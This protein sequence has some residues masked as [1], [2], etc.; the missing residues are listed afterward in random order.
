VG[1]LAA[2]VSGVLPGA[3]PSPLDHIQEHWRWSHFDQATGLPSLRVQQILRAGDGTVWVSTSKGAAW[4][5]GYFWHQAAGLG[6][7]PG[8]RLSLGSG[9]TIFAFQ[10]N[11]LYEGDRSGFAP[12]AGCQPGDWTDALPL[13][14]GEILA[15]TPAH[16]P[17]LFRSGAGRPAGFTDRL[18]LVQTS[19]FRQTGSRAV[20]WADRRGLFR[21]QHDSTRLFFAAQPGESWLKLGF[22]LAGL[23][24]N[25]AGA[26]VAAVVHPP[27]LAG[28]WEW[29]PGEAPR[30]TAAVSGLEDGRAIGV[31]DAGEIVLVHRS[32]HVWIRRPGEDWSE[33]KPLPAGFEQ[34]NQALFGVDGDLWLAT[35]TG[36][37]LYRGSKQGWHVW[38]HPFPDNRNAVNG[39]LQARDGTVWIANGAGAER[40][41]LEP[42]RGVL[43][44][45]ASYPL[46]LS[47]GVAEDEEG[48]I[49]I[50]SGLAYGGAWRWDGKSWRRFGR[51]QG[52]TDNRIHRINRDRRGR[53]W[54]TA[55]DGRWG[56]RP[57]EA[58]VY[59]L[60]KA[61][62]ERWDR[63]K[64][65][66]SNQVYSVAGTADGTLYF[67]SNEG[68]SRFG[69]GRW[70]HWRRQKELRSGSLFSVVTDWAGN[71]YWADR[72][73]GIGTLDEKGRARYFT[74]SD[75]LA[76]NE[77]WELA[78]D[79]QDAV[80]AAGQ[81]G[82]SVRRGNQWIRL[83]MEA[84]LPV[85]SAWPILR[86]GGQV[87][88]GL[89]AAGLACASSEARPD[90]TRVRINV[91]EEKDGSVDLSWQAA[92]N[93][94]NLASAAIE[95]RFR[96][97][98]GTWS[99]WSHRSEIR[100]AGLRSG[101][102]LVEVE[103]RG[104]DPGWPPARREFKV[105]G[106]FHLRP[107]FYVPI[108]LLALTALVLLFTL[109][110]R[111]R[112]NRLAMQL[113][114]HH[115]RSLIE[116]GLGGITLLNGGL[117]RTYES[118][119]V[120][121][122]LGYDPAF[123]MN[124]PRY[125]SLVHPD[126]AGLLREMLAACV[127]RD[128]AV[129]SPRYRV[130]HL[131]G[132]WI[133]LEARARNLLEDP[134]VRSIVVNYADVTGQVE[135][136][137]E[138]ERAKEQAERASR[139][140]SEFL[141][142]MSHEIRT[143]MNGITGMISLLLD[144]G[145]NAEQRDYAESIRGSAQALL[146]LI[147]DVLDVSRI[148]SGQL[149]I[150]SKPF[151]LKR[152]IHEVAELLRGLA[153]GKQLELRESIPA[154]LPEGLLGDAGRVRQVLVNLIGNAIKFTSR[155]SVSVRALGKL[156]PAGHCLVT[157]EVEDTGIGIPE[158]KLE[159]IFEQFVQADASTT[160]IYGGTGL[161]LSISRSLVRMMGGDL[162]VESVAG[163]GST[164]RAT[165]PLALAEVVA[166]TVARSGRQQAPDCR[167][168]RIL[169]A[170]D[171]PVN[172]RVA[173][174]M[175]EKLGASV[176]I[177]RNGHEA[178]EW[179]LGADFDLILMDCQ[180]P[181]MDGFEATRLVRAGPSPRSGV[182]IAA[183]TANAMSG[184]R[185]R[186]LAA[187]MDDF[188]AKPI[189]S[190]KLAGLLGRAFGGRA[191]SNQRSAVSQGAAEARM[192][193]S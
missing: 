176:E 164:F 54:F 61:G 58:G 35:E 116:N 144:T 135:A 91:V 189:D 102:H 143:P 27:R 57:E 165:L 33:V 92:S 151:N 9:S 69:G 107:V 85:E 150:E 95:T 146:E 192:L 34:V 63:G 127:A 173:L 98:G 44:R 163:R 125:G 13:E 32:G 134:A 186:C 113:R 29:G 22:H 46:G 115:Y 80:W 15:S 149:M 162:T 8:I 132:R 158:D 139:V 18:E 119:A 182:T 84:G 112:Q 157:I 78:V 147:N 94:G 74:E 81:G 12:V 155:G 86:V 121:R 7:H 67:A 105:E 50:S 23:A 156:G 31:S 128:G 131:D 66:L 133:W 124:T 183:L 42:G 93:L 148:E 39:L 96:L 70:T 193:K 130:R 40:V 14:S 21:M 152:T 166:E 140:K 108:C 99:V 36:V 52:L 73:N 90:L 25:A 160:R 110:R 82:V 177:A 188:L 56:D 10:S 179:A 190:E 30:R 154:E 26:G 28:V 138:L 169:L 172:Q 167:G 55:M 2:L 1:L 83:G 101:R 38:A 114:E 137:Q 16:R 45:L 187:G 103:S 141:A 100:L 104:M 88:T 123:L 118:P 75:G 19:E 77:V 111:T 49:W 174:R 120:Q 89:A 87:C 106:P 159:A 142:T 185:E 136:E 37:H 175:L 64:G 17:L 191:F 3:A 59:L 79:Q 24:E 126:D 51:A 62:F 184:D 71:P 109:M 60:N 47:T 4:Y 6:P 20:W 170:E 153:R 171:N 72:V 178:V 129:S 76:S 48:N 117:V 65:L 145:L 180:M 122:V 11:C 181:E 68:L 53:L 97:N 161:G 168:K 5:D 41:R 43:T